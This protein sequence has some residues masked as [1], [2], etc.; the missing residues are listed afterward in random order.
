[1]L[2]PHAAR[3]CLL[4]LTCALAA[5]ACAATS[6]AS[7]SA[8]E[9]AT[10]TTPEPTPAVENPTLSAEEIGK[11]FL[12]LVEGLKTPED[13]SLELVEE[14]TGLSLLQASGKKYYGYGQKLAEGWFYA[15]WF[16]PEEH[17]N[18]RG[19]GL[20]FEH[21]SDR[22][23]NMATVCNLDF[24]HYHNALKAMGFRDVPIHG[25]IGQLES[26]RYYK[27]D[28]TLSIVPQNVIAGE[29]GRLCVKSIGT[30]N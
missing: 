15:I 5:S 4:I 30:L 18:R 22:H 9:A 19:V 7:P 29:A 20:D 25:E 28:I 26:W 3:T 8:K 11:R 12:K 14:V 23:S 21:E 24:D 27:D 2:L 6:Q 16:Y 13:L 1:M 17:G 10:M